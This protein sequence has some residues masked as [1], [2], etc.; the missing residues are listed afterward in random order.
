MSPLFA[1]QSRDDLRRGWVDA[2]R[3]G[4]DGA[5]LS[6]LEAKIAALVHEHPE[7]QPLL[8][9]GDAA[10]GRDF[11]P[12]DGATNPFLHLSMHLAVREQVGTDRPTGIAGLHAALG[13][14]LG[15]LH[16]AEHAMMEALGEAL[17][18]AQRRGAPPDEAAY[19]EHLR[20]LAARRP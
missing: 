2:W 18:T 17:W 20:R 16:A 7:Y 3:R 9:S 14:R 12:E 1:G 11:R 8:E 13:A 5:V 4:R 19:L 15:S 10:I 6:P